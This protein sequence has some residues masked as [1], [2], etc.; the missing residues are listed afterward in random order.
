MRCLKRG[1]AVIAVGG[2]GGSYTDLDI[3]SVYLNWRSIRGTTLGSPRDFEHF[4][5]MVED[6]PWSPII[7][8]RWPLDE[9]EEAHR[10]LQSGQQFGKLIIEL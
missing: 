10:R 6:A 1:G 2:T 3:R 5:Q 9:I 4:L 7:D 8:S